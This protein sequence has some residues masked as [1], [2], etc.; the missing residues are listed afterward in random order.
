VN[1]EESKK[2]FGPEKDYFESTMGLGLK[3]FQQGLQKP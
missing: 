2:F 1:W 3:L